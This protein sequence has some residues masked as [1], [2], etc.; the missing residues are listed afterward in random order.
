MAGAAFDARFAE[1]GADAAQR[2]WPSTI[3]CSTPSARTANSNAALVP[4][5]P[6]PV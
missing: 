1:Q 6:P 5:W 3:T 4:W 2:A